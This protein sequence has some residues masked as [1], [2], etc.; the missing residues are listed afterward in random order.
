[1]LALP[2]VFQDLLSSSINIVDTFLVGQLGGT[3]ITAVGLANQVFFIFMIIV[4][5]INSSASIFMSQYWGVRD[6]ENIH[7]IMGIAMCSGAAVSLLFGA[8]SLTI[9]ETLMSVFSKDPE[10]IRLGAQFLRRAAFSFFIFPFTNS[11]AASLKCV[12]QTRIPMVCSFAAVLINTGLNFLLISG[13]LGFPAMGVR[14]SATATLVSRYIEF[15]LII[16][17][18]FLL[19]L[20]VAGKIKSYATFSK[21]L[22]KKFYRTGTFVIISETVWVVGFSMYNIAFK[23]SSADVQIATD[24]QTAVQISTVTFNICQAFYLGFGLAGGIILGNLMGANELAKAKAYSKTFLKIAVPMGVCLGGL[25]FGI[26]PLIIKVFDVNADVIRFARIILMIYSAGIWLKMLNF[27]FIVGIFRSGGDTIAAFIL[28]CGSVWLVALPLTLVGAL[29]FHLPIY[30]LVLLSFSEEIVKCVG[31][32]WRYTRFK[33][34]K[35]L[36]K[37]T[38]A[39]VF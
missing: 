38:E 29:V 7:K 11:V 18:T 6:T 20:P 36:T 9:P 17:I 22:V 21:A 30:F 19:K 37:T 10:V 8:V 24:S 12:G 13:H 5:G 1:M 25:L 4:F 34:V 15:I 27:M 32:F 31:G 33:W 23:F 16:T 26:S 3:A 35:N 28:D 39:E 2:M 14:G